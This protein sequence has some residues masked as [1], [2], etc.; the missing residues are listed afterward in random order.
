MTLLRQ[1]ITC[2][3][4]MIRKLKFFLPILLTFCVILFFHYTK[5]IYAKYYPALADFCIFML[6][7]TS[8]FQKET[9]IQRLARLAEPNIKPKAL[10][11][12]KKLTYV[13]SIFSFLNL[14]IATASKLQYRIVL[15]VA[16]ILIFE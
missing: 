13:W 12:T 10:I 4:K 1:F 15:I 8:L 2:C 3:R 6:F 9:I 14:C 11:Y 7:F 16:Y 5:I